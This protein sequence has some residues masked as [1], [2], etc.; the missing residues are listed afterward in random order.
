[1]LYR[2]RHIETNKVLV[3][4]VS[5]DTAVLAGTHVV[6][7]G[8]GLDFNFDFAVAFVGTEVVVQ[9]ELTKRIRVKRRETRTQVRTD[10]RRNEE[11]IGHDA[12][13]HAAVE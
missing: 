12:D 11:R 9:N 10:E 7:R 6:E 13:V 1:M 5:H 4:L 8:S 3:V 2:I